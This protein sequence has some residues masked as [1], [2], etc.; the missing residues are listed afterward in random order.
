MRYRLSRLALIA[1]AALLWTGCSTTRRASE[2]FLLRQAGELERRVEGSELR[3]AETRD[4]LR[5]EISQNL[6]ENLAEHEVVTW[7]I[8]QEPGDTVKVERVTDRTKLQVSSS[9]FQDSRVELRT[10]IVRDTV[11]IERRDSVLVQGSSTSEAT[12]FKIQDSGSRF[13]SALKWIFWILVAGAV[14]V[15]VLR[16]GRLLKC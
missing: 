16:F 12:G 5:E 13:V 6:N 7:T 10:E 14:V 4:S 11:Y 2:R 1:T 15:V 3:E 9:K 8:V